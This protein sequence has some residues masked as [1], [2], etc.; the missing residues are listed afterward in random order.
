VVYHALDDLKVV[1]Q[2]VE[3][4]R[5]GFEVDT[6]R[7]AVGIR[8]G[9]L[10]AVS[11]SLTPT[12]GRASR[13]GSEAPASCGAVETGRRGLPWCRLQATQASDASNITRATLGPCGAQM[14]MLCRNLT[15]RPPGRRLLAF[16]EG[17]LMLRISMYRFSR[18]LPWYRVRPWLRARLSRR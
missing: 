2:R 12:D 16:E 6:E 13:W 18:W 10:G 11:G 1:L 9:G 5:L 14:T 3:V 15:Y 8:P 7:P 4:R 17:K